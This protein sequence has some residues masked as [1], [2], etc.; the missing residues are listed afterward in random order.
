LLKHPKVLIFD[1]ATSSLDQN[2][3]EHFALTIN[4]FKG[5]VGMIFITHAMPKNLQVDE[6]VRIEQGNLSAVAQDQKKEEMVKH[7]AEG[8]VHA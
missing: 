6:I 1:E 5:R 3:A 7:K 2:T 8:G 4:Q